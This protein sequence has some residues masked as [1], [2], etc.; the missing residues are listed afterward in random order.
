MRRKK[1][2]SPPLVSLKM[3]RSTLKRNLLLR[4]PRSQR[5]RPRSLRYKK[6]SLMK[7]SR[8]NPKNRTSKRLLRRMNQRRLRTTS[9]KTMIKRIPGNLLRSS[10][11]NLM[12]KR[13]STRS[14]LIRR[15]L[16]NLG[17]VEEIIKKMMMIGSLK[18]TIKI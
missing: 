1:S 15:S 18:E 11:R 9:K 7:T 16:E 6:K 12:S 4:L 13:E 10:K 3:L 2:Q 5:R 14:A 17:E 8:N